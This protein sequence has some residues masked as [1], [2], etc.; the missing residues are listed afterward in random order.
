MSKVTAE[1]LELQKAISKL[2]VDLVGVASIS[3]WRNTPLAETALKLLPR[4]CSVVVVAMEV[5]R[6]VV[7][8]AA[9]GR[10]M[11]A[12]A[13]IELLDRNADYLSGRLTK[14]A[15][16]F[17][18]ASHNLVFK[19]LPLPAVGCPFDARSLTAVFS[20]KHAGQAAGVG[21]IGWSSLLIT[22]KFGPRVRLACCLTEAVLEPTTSTQEL[23]CSSCGVCVKKCPAKALSEPKNSDTYSIN[24]FA[25]SAFRS[26]SGG[27]SECIR[28]C[29]MG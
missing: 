15:Y 12:A 7:D 22:P 13:A 16:D 5:Y 4:A 29:P 11:G 10:T 24:K 28:L 8:L 19:A 3:E 20:Y 2:D 6:E 14:A 17:A 25:C 27:C 26:A 9:P 23:D 1:S 21:K 18:R